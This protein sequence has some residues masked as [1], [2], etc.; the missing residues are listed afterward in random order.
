MEE[1]GRGGEEQEERTDTDRQRD[2]T[3]AVDF[4]FLQPFL[5]IS[6]SLR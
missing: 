3:E 2:R 1:G 6:L 4:N 5:L